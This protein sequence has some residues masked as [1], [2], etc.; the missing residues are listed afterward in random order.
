MK[1]L[2]TILACILLTQGVQAQNVGIGTTTPDPSSKLEIASDTSGLLIP[3]MTTSQRNAISNPA[4]G[5]LV[6]VTTDSTFYYYNGTIWTKLNSQTREIV[7]KDGD[8]KVEVEHNPDDDQIRFTSTNKSI[9]TMNPAGTSLKGNFQQTP[10]P[11]VLAGSW[12]A[13]GG[14]TAVY[15]SG[16]YAYCLDNSV[17][18]LTIL[19]VSKPSNPNPV[20]SYSFGG[21]DL[22]DLVVS[23]RYAYV[24]NWNGQLR[25]IDI[26]NASAPTSV[27]S[28]SVG[29][30]PAKLYVSGRYV[31][32]LD[33]DGHL[34]IIDVSDPANPF[35]TGSVYLADVGYGIFV[36]GRYAYIPFLSTGDF[37]V[38]DV[39]NPSSPSIVGSLNLGN[40]PYALYVSGRY[41]Y[42][43]SAYNNLT[44]T[45]ISIAD[46]TAPTLVTS[47]DTG[48][49]GSVVGAVYVS[50]RYAYLTCDLDH[51]LIVVDVSNPNQPFSAG[52]LSVGA[53]P[54]DVYVSGRYAY[55]VDNGSSHNLSVISLSGSEVSSLSAHSMEA[56]N[57]QVRNDIITQGQL[58]VAGGITAGIG[59][60]YAAGDAGISGN[61]H[62]AG[63]LGIRT[64][65]PHYEL[66]IGNTGRAFFGD[67]GGDNR[68]GLLLDGIEG[69]NAARIEA[70]NYQTQTGMNLVL[71]TFGGGNIGIGTTTPT[72]AKVEIAGSASNN[73]SYGYLNSLG[74]T[75]TAS[76][77]NDYSLYADQRIAAGE[78]NAFSDARIKRI[79]G[80]SDSHK[81]LQTLMGIEITDY[82]LIDTIAKGSTPQKKVIAQQVEKVF[83]QA[84][85]ADLTDVIP[86]I[87]QRAHVE[88]GWILL[89]T[90][91]RAGERVK[92]ITSSGAEVYNVL[93]AESTRFKVEGFPTPDTYDSTI[94]VYGREVKDFHTVDYEAIAMLNVSA[95]Q[96]QQRLIE[97][98]QKMLVEYRTAI[99][100]LTERV[101]ALEAGTSDASCDTTLSGTASD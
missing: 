19:D 1:L 27:A 67:G 96:E 60:I 89:P 30:Y 52:S 39:S 64:P 5:L 24:A 72:K 91:L 29:V 13:I 33:Q 3:R 56:G 93:Q 82:R 28:F 17:K 36:L 25:I 9:M 79:L 68:K 98:Q 55:V 74:I 61:L 18:T 37:K 21:S 32:L 73:L 14:M 100:K 63:N 41:A 65:T 49:Y 40:H 85:T 23:G 51:S 62:L 38:I 78:F 71:N 48:F 4:N 101:D 16:S 86:D 58:Q 57:I 88:D 31:Y 10:D 15:V 75:G 7:D 12:T 84:V 81:D 69:T 44:L 77:T 45:V 54:G 97:A 11:P 87:Y 92:M 26:S 95:T 83:P 22:T 70:F 80:I 2:Y 34:N 20:G 94:F 46:P 8:T 66:E 76:G 6:F 59:G 50:G 35:T 90:D 42:V 99:D 43:V 53:A 47:F